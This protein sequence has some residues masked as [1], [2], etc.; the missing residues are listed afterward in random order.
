MVIRKICDDPQYYDSS[1]NLSYSDYSSHKNYNSNNSL[2]SLDQSS[3]VSN[4]LGSYSSKFYLFNHF[5][6]IKII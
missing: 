1:T 4:L 2:S 3:S 5:L 6:V